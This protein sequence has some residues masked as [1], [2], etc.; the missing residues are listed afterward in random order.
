MLDHL[1]GLEIEVVD[2]YMTEPQGSQKESSAWC[3]VNHGPQVF[4][5]SF[6]MALFEPLG[7]FWDIR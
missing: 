2:C 3:V 1:F 6:K 5:K 4:T 7:H